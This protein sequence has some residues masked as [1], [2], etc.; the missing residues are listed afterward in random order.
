MELEIDAVSGYVT[1]E[2]NTQWWLAFVLEVDD[3]NAEVKLNFLHPHGPFRSIKYPSIPDILMVPLTD[4]LTKVNPKT[5][6]SRTYERK[7]RLPQKNLPANT[8][9]LQD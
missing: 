7:V 1:C 5:P 6:T 4:I 2:Y 8:I 9:K 3:E